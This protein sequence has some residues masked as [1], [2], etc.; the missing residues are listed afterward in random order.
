MQKFQSIASIFL[1]LFIGLGI[2]TV[3][4]QIICL[5]IGNGSVSETIGTYGI[6]VANIF[7]ALLGI[8][9]FILAQMSKRKKV[10]AESEI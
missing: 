4:A 9:S 5:F 1:W 7:G 2:L 8:S 3:L 10:K 6:R